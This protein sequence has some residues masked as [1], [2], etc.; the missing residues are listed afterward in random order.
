[1]TIH[2]KELL[3]KSM[4]L[5]ERIKLEL[6]P[7][8]NSEE[9]SLLPQNIDG[10]D[11]KSSVLIFGINPSLS[12]N[13]NNRQQQCNLG[14]ID[15][16]DSLVRDFTEKGFTYPRYYR[17]NYELTPENYS[18]LWEAE[19][20]LEKN[21][22]DFDSDEMVFLK[23]NRRST[24]NYVTFAELVYYKETTSKKIQPIIKNLKNDVIEL[25]K[26]QLAYYNPNLVVITNAF[27]SHLI[28]DNPSNGSSQTKM[29]YDEIPILFA[30]MASGQRAL[31]KF[32]YLRLKKDIESY[33]GSNSGNISSKIR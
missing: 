17:G 26:M 33:L 20:F 32:S 13:D 9:L 31:D 6:N 5:I 24:G 21:K 8:G 25:F 22:D 14:Y 29:L 1:M 3:E 18:M 19:G 12:G 28:N 11:L 7:N 23:Q 15:S 27:T 4:K 30:G 2:Y 16:E 10:L